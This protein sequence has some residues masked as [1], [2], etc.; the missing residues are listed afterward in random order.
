[1]AR[2]AL[3][4][5]VELHELGVAIMRQNLRR[6]MPGATESEV[7]DAVAKWLR[8]PRP[9]DLGEGLRLVAEPGT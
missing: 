6:R 5:T 1:M 9:G 4:E 8:E 3:T 7:D 2:G